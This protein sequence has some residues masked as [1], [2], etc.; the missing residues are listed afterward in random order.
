MAEAQSPAPQQAQNIKTAPAP[1]GSVAEFL[2]RAEPLIPLGAFAMAHPMAHQLRGEVIEIARRYKSRN[3][4][5][6]K[7]GLPRTS[8]PPESG[9]LDPQLWLR[10]LR[11]IPA[12]KHAST[13][14]ATAFEQLMEK[15]FP[16]PAPR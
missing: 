14:L 1:R 15:R 10:H 2:I 5:Q 6:K 4:A 13:S 3:D 11:S 16:C 9:D 8:C 12:A 7:A